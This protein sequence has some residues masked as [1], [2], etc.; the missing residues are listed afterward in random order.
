ML[1]KSQ[2]RAINLMRAGENV[3]LTGEAGTGKSFLLK[4][5]I[6]E[7][8]GKGKNI[9]VCAPTGIAAVNVGGVTLHR[10][11]GLNVAMHSPTD[12]YAPKQVVQAAECVIIDE[13]SMCRTDVFYMAMKI[14][15]KAEAARRRKIQVIVVGDFYQLPPV[16]KEDDKDAFNEIW[17][18]EIEPLYKS[19]PGIGRFAFTTKMWKKMDFRFACLREVVRQDDRNFVKA[20]EDTR[21]GNFVSAQWIERNSSKREIPDGI[22]L[23]GRKKEVAWR[24]SAKLDEIDAKCYV[25]DAEKQGLVSVNDF[26]ADEYL[27]LKVGCR[28]MA[29]ANDT[30]G[31]YVNGDMGYVRGIVEHDYSGEFGKGEPKITVEFDRGGMCEIRPFEWEVKSYKIEH[32]EVPRIFKVKRLVDGEYKDLRTPVPV[33]KEYT[34]GMELGPDEDILRESVSKLVKTTIGRYKQIPLKLAYAI[35][36]HKSQGQTFDKVNLNPDCFDDGMLYVAL[37]RVRTLAG[38]HLTRDIFK[39]FLRTSPIVGRFYEECEKEERKRE[40]VGEMA[41]AVESAQSKLAGASLPEALPINA[42]SVKKTRRKGGRHSKSFRV[43][44]QEQLL[45]E[46]MYLVMQESPETILYM[47]K[48]VADSGAEWATGIGEKLLEYESPKEVT[49]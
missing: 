13:I 47:L 14:I 34:L 25:F 39:R 11:M 37:S 24:N 4:M 6:K 43:T 16:L 32:L 33:D 9:L 40:M 45:M 49:A 7:M 26:A 10:L 3:F 31:R 22:Y 36:I 41:K 44:N 29:L 18:R 38:L 21:V 28:V 20:L 2:E 27:E 1:T 17:G 30:L 15:H 35:T 42:V 48:K 8:E 12:E 5:F 46:S 19:M 23:A